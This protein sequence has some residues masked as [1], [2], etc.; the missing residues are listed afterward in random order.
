MLVAD[1]GEVGTWEGWKI[2]SAVR[3]EGMILPV[4]VISEELSGNG[5]VAAFLAG[6]MILCQSH[7]IPVN[8]NVEF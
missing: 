5:A 8:S 3:D 6:G 1:L 4:M 2:I 7:Y